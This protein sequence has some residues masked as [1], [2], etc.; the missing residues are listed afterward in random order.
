MTEFIGRTDIK[1]IAQPEDSDLCFATIATTLTGGDIEGA[2]RGL[3]RSNL[4]Q[5]DGLTVAPMQAVAVALEGVELKV[6]PIVTP[7]EFEI[8]SDEVMQ[9]IYEQFDQKNPVA[10]MHKKNTKPDDNEYHWSLLVG[11]EVSQ[12]ATEYITVMDSMQPAM[13]Q[14][15]PEMIEDLI[16]RSLNYAGVGACALSTAER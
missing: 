12:K 3:V 5:E 8:S 14:L 9:R 10:L 7:L 11:R 1:H 16:D 4:S 15:R 2:H 6:D 13:A